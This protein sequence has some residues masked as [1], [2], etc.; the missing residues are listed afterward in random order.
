MA[1]PP[2]AIGRSWQPPG[3]TLQGWVTALAGL[4]WSGV[5][6]L[7][8]QRDLVWPGLFLLALPLSS[9]LLLALSTRTPALRRDLS[10][11]ELTVGEATTSRVTVDSGGQALG[12]AVRYRDT[13]PAALRGPSDAS[14]PAGFGRHRIEH[15]L[16]A[17]WRGRH[18]IGPLR[19]SV[20]DA[21]GLARVHRV[22]PG[23]VEV[24]ALPAVSP[25]EPQRGAAGIGSA[26]EAVVRKTSLIGTDDVLVREYLPGDD[27]RRIHWRS[28]ARTG[29]LMVRRE[30]Q[31]WDP[32]AVLLIDNRAAAYS[33]GAGVR[34]AR[35]EVA[36]EP[37][38]GR[39]TWRHVMRYRERDG[40]PGAPAPWGQPGA[41]KPEPRFEW[42]VS[43]AASIAVHLIQHGFAVALAD[44]DALAEQAEPN[45]L[46][47]EVVLRRLADVELGATTGLERAVAASPTG[48]RGQL[49]IALL[50]RLDSADAALLSA[51]RRDHQACWAL[52]REPAV[53]VPEAIRLLETSGWR[54]VLV[55]PEASVA[56]AWQLLGEAAG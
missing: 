44:A 21:L 42:L 39:P 56:A 47:A 51:A 50:G 18:A 45:R 2:A 17:N 40:R 22:L 55:H 37:A 3:L 5:A 49:L 9:W 53:V 35:P 36:P 28:T 27:V 46:G 41:E 25:L 48:A 26:A 32:S 14:R 54:V 4:A 15:R 29:E 16:T 23:T 38:P 33:G 6:W 12:A 43:A 24:L 31:A 34:V 1:M 20:T 52:V 10:P 11:G 13:Y 30:E 7:T 8:G 19:R